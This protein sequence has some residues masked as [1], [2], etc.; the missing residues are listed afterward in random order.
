MSLRQK[1]FA[2]PAL[3]RRLMNLYPPYLGAGVRVVRVAEDFGE[4]CVELRAHALNRNAFGTHFGGSLYSMTDPFFAL[5]MTAR[6]GRDYIVWDK[7]ASI[8]FVR[9]GTGT[10]S[11]C[12]KLSAK[13]VCEAREAV[14]SVGKFEP[15]YQAEIINAAGKVVA[16]VSKTLHVRRKKET[17]SRA[18]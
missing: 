13:Q 3:F 6:L 11:A 15:V 5:M 10:V 1:L 14:A 12:F 4:V 8:D 16:R 2:R 17:L 7:A 9:P 18:A